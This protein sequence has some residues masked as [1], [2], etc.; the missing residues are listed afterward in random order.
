MT[1]E[2][3]LCKRL[4]EL[5]VMRCYYL[6]LI[7]QAKSEVEGEYAYTVYVYIVRRI[8]ELV[9]QPSVESVSATLWR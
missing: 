5:R 7:Q 8:N 1:S 2:E 6:N 4:D 9:D 3:L